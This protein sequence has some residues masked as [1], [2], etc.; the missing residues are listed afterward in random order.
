MQ[1]PWPNLHRLD[2]YDTY[3]AAQRRRAAA[4]SQAGPPCPWVEDNHTARVRA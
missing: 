1:T 3:P 2:V 4:P